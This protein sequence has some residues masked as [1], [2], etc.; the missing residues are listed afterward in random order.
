MNL[1]IKRLLLMAMLLIMATT[2]CSDRAHDYYNSASS[3]AAK[4]D[5]DGAIADLTKA[6]ELKPN[7]AE[8]YY[9]RGFAKAAER[10]WDGAIADCTK[11][12]ELKPDYAKACYNRGNAK[13]AKGD[14]EGAK[15]DYTK[16]IAVDPKSVWPYHIRGCIRY[17]LHDFT[18]A[19]VDFR[20]ALELDPSSDY[21]HFR[22]WLIC[23][24]LGEGEPATT[25][26]QTY[27][28]GRNT[29]RTNDWPSKVDH[30][31]TGRV[32]ETAFLAAAKNTNR[33]TEAGRLCEAYFYTGSK[34]LL[35]GDQS[36]AAEYFQKSITTDEKAFLECDSATAELKFLSVKEVKP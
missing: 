7:H 23:A 31:L 35:A 21:A 26:L 1:A 12:I 34:H 36:L 27:M 10:D 16:A 13:K 25:E 6:I 9:N 22:V 33:K 29:G 17:D 11:A 15:A 19:L 4:R 8:A 18:N 32:T 14:F 28:A 20:K 30:F 5:W 2:S 24:R 3:K